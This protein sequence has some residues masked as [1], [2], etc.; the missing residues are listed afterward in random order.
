MKITIKLFLITA[1][2]FFASTRSKAQDNLLDRKINLSTDNLSLKY[3]LNDIAQS[4]DFKFSYNTEIING[5][6]LIS[7]NYNNLSVEDCLNNLFH[8]DI[9]YKVSGDHIILLKVTEKKAKKELHTIS[10]TLTDSQ[11]KQKLQYVSVYD[12]DEKYSTITNANG[13]YKLEV[14]SSNKY[15]AISYNKKDY[16]DTIIVIKTTEDLKI[17]IELYPFIKTGASKTQQL[18]PLIEE[19]NL[20]NFLIPQEIMINSNNLKYISDKRFAQVSFL[21]SIGTNLSSYG[22]I[23]NNFS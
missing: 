10:G 8:D 7:Y 20:T 13:F 1:F 18:T 22:V 12:V 17:N 9:R 4:A 21:P 14:P 19:Y 6:S 15:R 2:L 3:A 5:D 23:E 11:T 16:F